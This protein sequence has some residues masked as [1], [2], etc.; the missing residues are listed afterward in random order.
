MLYNL[1]QG[2]GSAVCVVSQT[3]WETWRSSLI[4]MCLV[5]LDLIAPF[6]CCCGSHIELIATQQSVLT[7]EVPI[8]QERKITLG[9]KQIKNRSEK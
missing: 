7:G 9:G 8:T 2:R 3:V 4:T 1:S 5:I 6:Y